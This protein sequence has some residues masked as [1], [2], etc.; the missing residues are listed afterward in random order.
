L[1][2]KSLSDASRAAGQ[3]LNSIGDAI[4]NGAQEEQIAEWMGKLQKLLASIQETNRAMTHEFGVILLRGKNLSGA[5]I[6]SYVRVNMGQMA[7]MYRK[8]N[9]GEDFN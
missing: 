3:A 4:Q 2:K 9:S 5:R 6:Y 1:I 8:L 7:I